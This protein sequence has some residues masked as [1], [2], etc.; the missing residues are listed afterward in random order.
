MFLPPETPPLSRC[1]PKICG[2]A[3]HRSRFRPEMSCVSK[4]RIPMI[5]RY[6]IWFWRR[7]QLPGGCP[8]GNRRPW[9]P[10]SSRSEERR[11]G[12]EGG[13][14]GGPEREREKEQREGEE[15]RSVEV[16]E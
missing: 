8:R 3:H 15:G 14:R 5:L 6:M 12:K 4:S 2:L 16:V 1:L 13:G 10:V 9:K 11:V 7:A